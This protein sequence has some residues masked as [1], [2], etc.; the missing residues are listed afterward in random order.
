MYV[1][2]RQRSSTASAKSPAKQSRPAWSPASAT[3]A[4]FSDLKPGED[5]VFTT[6]LTIQGRHFQLDTHSAAEV[7]YLALA[8]SLSDLAAMGAGPAF[9]LVSIAL[10]AELS[11]AWL[12]RFYTGLLTLAR[13][14][15][16]TLA[17]GDLS[18]FRSSRC[19]CHVLWSRPARQGAHSLWR[20]AGRW[21]LR[22]RCVGRIGPW[23]TNPEWRGLEAAPSP[24]TSPYGRNCFAKDSSDCSHGSE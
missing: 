11:T 13:Q 7:G 3:I 8:R 18:R 12:K 15:D 17:G 2:V 9:C 1:C 19:R 21:H 16:I 14:S 24:A 22:D 20:Q 23:A 4:P 5:L 6:D 10:P